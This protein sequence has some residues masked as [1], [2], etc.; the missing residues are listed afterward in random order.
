VASTL[1]QKDILGTAYDLC[2]DKRNSM[3]GDLI[4]AKCKPG[5]V[6][7]FLAVVKDNTQGEPLTLCEVEVYGEEPTTRPGEFIRIYLK[8]GDSS[9]QGGP[10]MKLYND[11][12]LNRPSTNH[13]VEMYSV[14][15]YPVHVLM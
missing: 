13:F 7:R 1:N 3:G 5:S 8:L 12:V 10:R 2:S 6:G 4:Q 15:N 9:V 11:S 14:F